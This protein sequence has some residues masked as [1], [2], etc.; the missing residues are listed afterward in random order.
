MSSTWSNVLNSVSFESL[1]NASWEYLKLNVE[2]GDSLSSNISN[3]A[4]LISSFVSL[5]T[6]ELQQKRMFVKYVHNFPNDTFTLNLYMGNNEF[7]NLDLCISFIKRTI[8]N[9]TPKT[10][11][12]L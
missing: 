3:A 5:G 7:R 8:L 9:K 2:Y 4:N 6:P 12:E 1:L 11:L 10:H